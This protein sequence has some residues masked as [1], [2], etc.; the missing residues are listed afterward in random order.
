M[1]GVYRAALER[2]TKGGVRFTGYERQWDESRIVAIV[3]DGALVDSATSGQQAEIVVDETPFYGGTEGQFGDTGTITSGDDLATVAETHEPMRGLVLHRVQV[4]RGT[5]AV[6]DRASLEIDVSRRQATRQNHSAAH[7]VGWALRSM[8]GD[9]YNLRSAVA[10]PNE[11]CLEI[12]HPARLTDDQIASLEAL[13]HERVVNNVPVWTE[14]VSAEQAREA[15][16]GQRIEGTD[17]G[18][19]RLIRMAES[20]EACCGT[21]VRATG[22]IG[23]VLVT[24]Q[25]RVGAEILRISA[26]TGT[27]ALEHLRRTR[28]LSIEQTSASTASAD[29]EARARAKTPASERERSSAVAPRPVK[30]PAPRDDSPLPAKPVVAQDVNAVAARRRPTSEQHR[31]TSRQPSV[32]PPRIKRWRALLGKLLT[33]WR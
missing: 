21:H 12:A 24:K 7:L 15:V 4:I 29:P 3:R 20:V 5:F 6:G 17:S 23:L 2:V 9:G 31:V 25:T 26:M 13:V 27:R 16:P 10:G 18:R 11:L 28:S 19:A 8:L 32:P 1:Q 22:E 33:R 30:P 14:L